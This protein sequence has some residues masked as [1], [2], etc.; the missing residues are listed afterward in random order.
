MG[1][2]S[3]DKVVSDRPLENPDEDCLNRKLFA[4]RIFKIIEGTPTNTHLRIGINGS[5]G[6]GKSTVLNFIKNQCEGKYPI[7]SFN[8]WHCADPKQAWA[9]F[10]LSVDTGLA[11][12]KGKI[13][14]EVARK[15]VVKK[16][17]TTTKALAKHL[18]GVP[19]VSILGDF[20]GHLEGFL[21]ENK[22]SVQK[23]LDN[24]LGAN[25]RVIVFIDDLDRADP[26]VLYGLL[27]F[28]NE[29]VDLDRCIYIIAYDLDRA[30]H[31][32]ESKSGIKDGGKEFLEKIINW[33]FD[34]PEPTRF[35]LLSLLE[36]MLSLDEG[37]KKDVL[38]GIFDVM[39]RNP[40][41]LKAFLQYL[42][43]LHRSFLDR[44]ADDELTWELLY[45]TQLLRFEF[46]SEYKLISQSDAFVEHITSSANQTLFERGYD[47]DK[48]SEPEWIKAINDLFEELE[49]FKKERFKS[50]VCGVVKSCSM[51]DKS[52]VA[53]H[54]RIMD[55]PELL[56]W[57]EYRDLKDTCNTSNGVSISDQLIKFLSVT[58]NLKDLESAREF[59]RKLMEERC[60]LYSE[61]INTHDVTER[62][63]IIDKVVCLN[64][65]A[66]NILN[67]DIFGG[68]NPVFDATLFDEWF[69]YLSKNNHFKADKSYSEIW[70]GEQALVK[71]MAQN[72]DISQAW[73]VSWKI[74]NA[75]LH[76]QG[77]F[78]DA[79]Q[80][81][82]HRCAEDI[83]RHF[84]IP[85]GILKLQGDYR[86]V[87][88]KLLFKLDSA[89]HNEAIHQKICDLSV[90]AKE[91]KIILKNFLDL[92]FFHFDCIADFSVAKE[93]FSRPF[94]KSV[95]D[96]AISREM[97]M[98]TI[99]SLEPGRKKV[100]DLFENPD[101][102][103]VPYWWHEALKSG[104]KTGPKE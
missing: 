68:S 43:G 1:K 42:G 82:K 86:P 16:A 10:A 37:I 88:N 23:L 22:K 19:G 91:N 5:W 87:I 70:N 20:L 83:V 13:I 11:K 65:M 48:K 60:Q 66:D 25:A 73:V 51:L 77:L 57:K 15:R 56:T 74:E 27:M 26:D 59:L 24:E 64:S 71:T 75:P 61:A 9:N 14:G 84:S 58:N 7:A 76:E 47:S 103:P 12:W 94:F 2:K 29:I 78:E 3:N 72:I 21:E 28:L 99:G 89:F 40:R 39:P 67:H 35:E 80:I 81:L 33:R 69:E 102:L 36:K 53:N 30:A 101:H 104:D 92:T 44:F 41:K 100:C 90:E 93:V 96:T 18:N 97:N 6:S 38:E 63:P 54:F 17:S 98:R 45:L 46:P 62:Q 34:L 4:E 55:T 95:W 31:I 8:P 49:D 50:I 85:D 79:D 32:I 52:N